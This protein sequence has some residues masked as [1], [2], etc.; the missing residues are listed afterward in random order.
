MK[1]YTTFEVAE[2]LRVS[3]GTIREWVNK[4]KLNA[5]RLGGT[6]TIR[7][8]EEDLERFLSQNKIKER[9]VL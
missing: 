6:K 4:G 2:I 8:S 1:F 9:R 7:I 3:E 5:V